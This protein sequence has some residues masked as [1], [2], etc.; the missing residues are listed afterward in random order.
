M[1]SHTAAPALLTLH[2]L[3]MAA[4]LTAMAVLTGCGAGR[5]LPPSNQAGVALH[6]KVHG[7]QQPVANAHVYLFAANTTGY[8]GAGILPT[9]N[10]ASLSLLNVVDTTLSDDT[11]AYVLTDALGN[12]DISN[13]YTCTP[14]SQ[15]YLYVHGGDP[16]GGPNSA[17]GLLAILGNCPSGGTFASV[18][19]IE[20]NEV[21]TVTA[22][23]SFAGFAS[24]ATHVSSYPTSQSL[25]GI[26]NAF[27]TASNLADIAT[28]TALTTTPAGNGTVPNTTIN[29]LANILASCVN[30]ADPVEPA[31][32]G[33]P[34][35]L[36]AHPHSDLPYSDACIS[37]AL[38]VSG[39][40]LNNFA[41]YTYD[42]A[43]AAIF[44]AQSPSGNVADLYTMPT[45]QAPF[46][47]ALTAQPNDFTHAISFTGGGNNA[48]TALAVDATGSIWVANIFGTLAKLSP[49]GVPIS[50][51]GGFT[52]GGLAFVSLGIAID[53]NGNAWITGSSS[54]DI[55]EFSNTG[56]ALSTSAGFT[57]DG[58]NCPDVPAIDLSG[59]IWA[60]N[61]CA[62]SLSQFDSSGTPAT[63]T[64]F[65]GAG[66]SQPVSVA[67]DTSGNLWA[68]NSNSSISELT[69]TGSPISTSTG[70]TGGG[71]NAPYSIAVDSFGNL[72]TANF[73]GNTLSE[74]T[75]AGAA[76][77]PSAGYT[78]GG[79]NLPT[80]LSIDG[81]GNVWVANNGA[82]SVSKFSSAGT[83]ISPSTG[84]T[85]G[86]STA[87]SNPYG[88]AVDSAGNVWI[89]SNSN[90]ISEL[91][92]AAAPVET[93]LVQALKDA[94]IAQRPC[95]PPPPPPP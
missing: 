91:V 3:W 4:L 88:I 94:C 37:L 52:G 66:L 44:I 50:P 38:A 69:S 89:S 47:P 74:F 41:G 59:N 14:N 95:V 21:S 32:S 57:G 72:W 18:P 8:G 54:N 78:G 58:L 85:G 83:A 43:T 26:A 80:N 30:T 64:G 13:D 27:A 6:G 24:D 68:A 60:P 2:A 16:G 33:S 22:A 34:R 9:V 79:L 23:Y 67:I 10:N 53:L 48:P 73:G 19:F 29:T 46:S 5:I 49:L 31:I 25:T 61:D 35:P 84:Y 15:V 65:T 62:A 93:P 76:I 1:R 17:I 90:F 45:P 75:N 28:A 87:I 63:G 82:P 86:G 92:G 70:F 51:S 81:A 11:G 71:L 42:T 36:K 20:I 12:F 55:S 7:G 40:N 56:I 77:S 39:D